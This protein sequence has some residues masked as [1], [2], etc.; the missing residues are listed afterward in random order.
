MSA[1]EVIGAVAL[2]LVILVAILWSTGKLKFSISRYQCQCQKC[3][4]QGYRDQE[5][6]E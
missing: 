1:L 6:D 2:A 5:D 4:P 3:F